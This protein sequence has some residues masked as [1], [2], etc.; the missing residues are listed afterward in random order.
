MPVELVPSLAGG[1]TAEQLAVER[2]HLALEA[3]ARR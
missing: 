1:D 2:V 3:V